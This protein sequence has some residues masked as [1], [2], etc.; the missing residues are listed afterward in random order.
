MLFTKDQR[1][2]LNELSKALYGSESKWQKELNAGNFR[3]PVGSVEIAEERETVRLPGKNGKPG[4]ILGRAKAIALKIVTEEQV[5]AMY[6]RSIPQYRDPTYEDLLGAF[7][8]MIDAR[9]ISLMP[10]SEVIQVLAYRYSRNELRFPV[11]LVKR[12]NDDRNVDDLLKTLPEARRQEIQDLIVTEEKPASGLPLDAFQFISDFGFALNHETQALALV[13]DSLNAVD[14][15]PPKQK[16]PHHMLQSL[17]VAETKRKAEAARQKL[18]GDRAKA[19][20]ARKARRRQRS[21]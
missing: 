17:A 18:S 7:D 9:K 1:Q 20:A 13:T 4:Q 15:Q 10:M 19:K 3:I 5:P 16:V 12:D 11:S 2:K 14:I 6:T 21:A 8:Q